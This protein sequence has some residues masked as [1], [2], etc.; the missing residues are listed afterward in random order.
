[1]AAGKF[2]DKRSGNRNTFIVKL[3]LILI[4]ILLIF[5]AIIFS[6][7]YSRNLREQQQKNQ[8]EAFE[9]TIESMKQI[10]TNYLS[11]ELGYARY[12]AQYIDEHKMTLG[13]ALDYIS[14]ANNQAERYAHIVD[15]KTLAAYSSYGDSKITSV[16]CYLKFSEY[17]SETNRIFM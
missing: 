5:S 2:V 3:I 6:W 4:N 14:Q 1:M 17:D 7:I 15:M 8:Q 16:N 10:S 11:M 9:A 13:E 12:W